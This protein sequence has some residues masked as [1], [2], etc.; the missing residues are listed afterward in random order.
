MIKGSEDINDEE[1]EEEIIPLNDNFK[2]L[3]IKYVIPEVFAF[4]IANAHYRD[5]L[6]DATF[7]Q[8]YH[9]MCDVFN[10]F[11]DSLIDITNTTVDL[12]KI[13]YNLVITNDSPMKIEKWQ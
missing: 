11:Y 13:K 2:N 9:S 4:E 3:M 5:C 10:G 8:H 12:L 1:W 7:E 6:C